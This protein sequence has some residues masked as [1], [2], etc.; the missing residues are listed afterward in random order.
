MTV[1]LTELHDGVAVITIDRPEA[2][3]AIDPDVA[4]GLEAAIDTIEED[5][6]IRAA[7]LTGRAPVFCAGADLRAVGAGD[8]PLLSTERGGF[9][10]FVQRDRTV[11]VIAAVEGAALAGGFELVLACDLVV[12]ST[13]ARFGLPEVTRGLVASAGGL[14]RVGRV[15]PRN[16]GMQLALTGAP[17]DAELAHHHGLVNLLCEPGSALETARELATTI[18]GNAPLAV[19]ASRAVVTAC[20]FA[21]DATGWE[22]SFAANDEVVASEDIEEGVRAFIEKRPPVWKGR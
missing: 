8:G 10:G 16:L 7:I 14:F 12:A 13:A 19:R 9:A 20:T 3:N 17:I 1:V 22:R 5:A 6:S 2:R 15:L 4:R 21:D 11:P 18:A